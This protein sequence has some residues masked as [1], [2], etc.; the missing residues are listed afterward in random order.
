MNVVR[1]NHK[2]F[3]GASDWRDQ[4]GVTAI[5]G[6]LRAWRKSPLTLNH[7]SCF[8]TELEAIIPNLLETAL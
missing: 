3:S 2:Q 1:R 4:I 5:K 8:S 6:G 7:A